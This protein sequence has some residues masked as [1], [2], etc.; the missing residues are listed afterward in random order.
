M[1]RK[2]SKSK[3]NSRK[4]FKL[5]GIG[6]LEVYGAGRKAEIEG[7]GTEKTN[8]K[9]EAKPNVDSEPVSIAKGASESQEAP[10]DPTNSPLRPLF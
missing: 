5:G 10:A 1:P 7:K 8:E 2:V 9:E 6:T 3:S 4:P